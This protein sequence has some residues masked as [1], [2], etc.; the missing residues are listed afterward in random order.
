[1]NKFD[2]WTDAELRRL[3]TFEQETSAR[4]LPFV[5]LDGDIRPGC[6][7]AMGPKGDK[8]DVTGTT[9]I[10]LIDLA[11]H[12]WAR[13]E[14][15]RGIVETRLVSIF[16]EM[17]LRPSTH[18]DRELWETGKF[19]LEDPWKAGLVELPLLNQEDGRLARY[20]AETAFQRGPIPGLVSVFRKKRR[21]PIIQLNYVDDPKDPKKRMPEFKVIDFDDGDDDLAA[22]TADDSRDANESSVSSANVERDERGLKIDPNTTSGPS[23]GTP[24]R[25]KAGADMDDDIPFEAEWR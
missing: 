17:P 18:A 5:Y 3:Q 16:E 8:K 14:K 11:K 19:G 13:R 6:G 2:R 20:R 22:L 7:F 12:G 9:W 1:V 25:A 4:G 15:G 23:A 21:R 10:A 24:A